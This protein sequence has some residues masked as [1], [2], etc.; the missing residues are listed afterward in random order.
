MAAALVAGVEHGEAVL[1]VVAQHEP[2]VVAG[3]RFD[4][5]R[6]GPAGNHVQLG[7]ERRLRRG[8]MGA[9]ALGHGFAEHDQLGGI[10]QHEGIEA[11]P[12]AHDR[13][14]GGQHLELHQHIWIEVV[15]EH[16]VGRAGEPVH[17]PAHD[18]Q[19]GRFGGVEE[20]VA[21]PGGA[22]QA[23]RHAGAEDQAVHGA[24][25]DALGPEA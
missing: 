14:I 25:A 13:V 17:Q 21:A 5:G 3:P 20:K 8:Q 6:I 24:A 7:G 4:L 10:A 12:E 9:Q 2:V 18:R 15:E 1:E 22:Q 19:I 16:D 23:N 11:A